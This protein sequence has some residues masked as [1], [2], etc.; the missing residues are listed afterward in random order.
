LALHFRPSL[1]GLMDAARR[2]ALADAGDLLLLEHEYLSI[3]ELGL[4]GLTSELAA[5]VDPSDREAWSEAVQSALA[6]EREK[7]F[8]KRRLYPT[9]PEDKPY[10]CYYPMDKRRR[11]GQNWYTLPL[12]ERAALMRAHGS[13]GRSY[14]GKISQVISGSMGLADW[15]WAVTLWAADPTEFKNIISE[16]RFD[17]AS[18]EY[19]EFGPFYVGV[20]LT[21]EDVRDLLVERA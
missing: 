5:R 13:V 16:M 19:A 18:A 17:E 7:A 20:R 2:L 3:V 4:Y 15:E 10:I 12:E 8:V 6:E 21:P 14:A 9:Q 11:P 1:E